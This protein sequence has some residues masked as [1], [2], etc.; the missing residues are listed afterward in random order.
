MSRRNRSQ[1]AFSLFAFQDIITSVTA[2]LILLVLIL[3]LELITRRHEAHAADP[4]TSRAALAATIASLESLV[5]RLSASVPQDELRPLARRTQAELER[6]VRIVEDQ[7]ARAAADAEAAQAVEARAQALAA[8]AAKRLAEA[9]QL[10]DEVT[11]LEQQ[12]ERTEEEARTLS[13]ENKKEAER[14]SQRREEIVNTPSPGAELVFNATEDFD[15]QAWIVEVSG[16]GFVVVKLGTNRRQELGGDVKADSPWLKWVTTMN[17][18]RDHALVLV[19]PSGVD[20]LEDVRK[21]LRE[22]Q[23]PF[24]VDFI[25]EGQVVRDGTGE[26]KEADAEAE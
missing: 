6:D 2:I 20:R 22:A 19:R 25:G 1:A 14:Q 24:G 7:A 3:S 4:A 5:G 11:R 16:E 12:A 10:R 23:V 26:A 18:D 13:S 21:A 17:S 15:R 9:S 8:A